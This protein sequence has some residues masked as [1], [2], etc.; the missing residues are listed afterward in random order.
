MNLPIRFRGGVPFWGRSHIHMPSGQKE[1][2]SVTNLEYCRIYMCTYYVRAMSTMTIWFFV[3]RSRTW[4][5]E[6]A[7]VDGRDAPSHLYE[8]QYPPMSI[9]MA[10][11]YPFLAWLVPTDSQWDMKTSW[12]GTYLSIWNATL[13]SQRLDGYQRCWKGVEP[14]TH[15]CVSRCLWYTVVDLRV[16]NIYNPSTSRD[17]GD[18]LMG[19]L[20]FC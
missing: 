6:A 18:K 17:V 20:C 2:I 15:W 10:S 4:R 8:Y 16:I 3:R 9:V 5:R 14:W 1:R 19:G 7:H 13:S 12:R 11:L